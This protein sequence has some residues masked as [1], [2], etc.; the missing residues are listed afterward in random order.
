MIIYKFRFEQAREIEERNIKQTDDLPLLHVCCDWYNKNLHGARSTSDLR[1][2]VRDLTTTNSRVHAS[3]REEISLNESLGFLPD[4]LLIISSFM[5][6]LFSCAT[7]VTSFRTS[8]Q[9]SSQRSLGSFLMRFSCSTRFSVF[10]F[11]STLK[12]FTIKPNRR[13]CE[14]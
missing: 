6:F 5:I 7:C 4:E 12:K 10:K 3:T 8:C 9:T 14:N 11:F 1:C 13:E 2:Q